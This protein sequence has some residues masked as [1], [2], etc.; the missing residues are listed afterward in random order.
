MRLLPCLLLLFVQGVA[1]AA[2]APVAP[3]AAASANEVSADEVF[4]PL[5]WTSSRTLDYDVVVKSTRVRGQTRIEST[6]SEVTRIATATA[7]SANGQVWTSREQKMAF[8]AGYPP[9][10]RAIVEA[11]QKAL[12]GLPLQ[13]TLDAHGSTAGLA[14][15][16]EL[17]PKIRQVMDTSFQAMDEKALAQMPP[18]ERDAA[19][20]KLLAHRQSVLAQIGSEGALQSMLLRTPGSLNFPGRGGLAPGETLNY[21]A[22]TPSAIGGATF[23][24][25]ATLHLA[26][27]PPEP[28]IDELRYETVLDPKDSLPLLIETVEKLAGQPLPPEV[29]AQLPKRVDVRT[30]TTWRIERATGIVRRMERVE[31]RSILGADDRNELT[32]TLKESP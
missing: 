10:Q 25:I 26:A 4:W 23:P 32:M 8:G 7:G 29:R 16:A 9:D 30:V 20:A 19:R 31:T 17:A 27:T 24:T 3:P 1:F 21:D 6:A 5:P 13:V 15:L 2:E 28:G 11:L 18:A 12:D 14:N 22:P